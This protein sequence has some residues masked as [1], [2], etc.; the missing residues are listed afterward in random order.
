MT[1]V[2]TGRVKFSAI[3][4]FTKRGLIFHV[5][6]L[7][8]GDSC[9]IKPYFPQNEDRRH[10][11]LCLQELCWHLKSFTVDNFCSLDPD[12]AQQ[13]VRPDLNPNYSI[14]CLI[15]LGPNCRSPRLAPHQT[16]NFKKKNKMNLQLIKPSQLESYFLIFYNVPL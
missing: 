7:L 10:K 15:D 5:N 9:N 16:D 14:I 3:W 12:H 4:S 1:F 8:A 11:Y 6:S 13:N 2:M